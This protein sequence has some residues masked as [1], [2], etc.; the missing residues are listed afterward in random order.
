M[1][2][3]QL[4]RMGRSSCKCERGNRMKKVYI[5]SPYRGDPAGNT[6]KAR[7]YCLDAVLAGC[8]PYAPHIYFTQFLDDEEGFGRVLGTALGLEWLRHCDELWQYGEPTVGMKAEIERAL[9]LGL[10]VTKK[11]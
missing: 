1:Q 10:P 5:C 3:L 11:G 2:I 6:Q 8:V 7:Q 9:E 4:Y